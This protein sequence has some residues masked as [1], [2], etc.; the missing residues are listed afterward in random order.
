MLKAIAVAVLGSGLIIGLGLNA[1]ADEFKVIPSVTLRG[2]YNDNVFFDEDNEDSDYI[3][4]VSPG[5]EI[6]DR[7]ERLNL[8]L[9]G[10]FHIIR[11]RDAGDLDAEDY[12]GRGAISYQ[13][14]PVFRGSASAAYVKDSSAG[15]D[16]D[17]TGLVQSTDTRRRQSYG[18][19]FDYTLTEKASVDF[20]Y[21]FDKSD[22][23]NPDRDEED[24]K[25][26]SAGAGFNYNLSSLLYE[27]TG[28][29]AAGYAHYDYETSKTDYYYGTVGAMWR[30]SEIFSLKADVGARYTDTQFKGADNNTKW[31]GLGSAALTYHGEFTTADVS[32]G[33][34][35]QAASGRRGVV[36]RTTFVLDVRHRFLEKL[37]LGVSAGYYLN[38]SSA[39]EFAAEKID[40]ETL[41]VRPYFNWGIH[42]YVSLEGAYEY[43]YVD[44]NTDNT[45]T[46]RNQVYL[47]VKFAYP[48]IE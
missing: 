14:T 12:D 24:F 16:I 34:D 13:F 7:T 2:E 31:G 27:T 42:R 33:R 44:D 47:Q 6:I 40:E 23:D 46:D 15:R 39:D 29:L 37:W 8:N 45:D 38:E 18:A 28:R 5:L 22:F 1:G 43:V 20:S 35:I 26:H 4:K 25:S 19:G 3:G 41:R 17:E 11:Y 32:A 21:A 10:R 36:E 48:V 30:F 9:N